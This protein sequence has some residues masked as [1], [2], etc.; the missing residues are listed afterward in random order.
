[1]F[2]LCIAQ[3]FSKEISK[4][5]KE[6]IERV[7]KKLEIA[8]EQPLVYFEKLEGFNLYKTRI[9]KF[10]VIASINFQLK[11]ITCLS[12]RLRKNVYRKL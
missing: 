6:E 7:S 8:A 9:G 12:V 10:R 2:E 3:K 5:Q 4:L 1:M 11:K